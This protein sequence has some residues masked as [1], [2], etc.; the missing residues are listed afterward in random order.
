LSRAEPGDQGDGDP[1]QDADDTVPSPKPIR[2]SGHTAGYRERRGFTPEDVEA[3]IRSGL[4][5][6]ARG[7]RLEASNDRPYGGVWNGTHVPIKRVRA[8]FVDEPDENIVVA[9][10]TNYF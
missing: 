9:V 7:D 10:Y 4:W 2:L 6:P 5:Q 8:V 3:A 1:S